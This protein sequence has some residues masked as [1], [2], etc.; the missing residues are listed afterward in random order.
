VMMG[1]N[2]SPRALGAPMATNSTARKI[3]NDFRIF[4]TFSGRPYRGRAEA[5][6]FVCGA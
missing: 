1:V 2:P 4:P 6:E 5:L 3:H